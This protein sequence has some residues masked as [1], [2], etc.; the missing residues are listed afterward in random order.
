MS[1]GRDRRATRCAGPLRVAASSVRQSPAARAARRPRLRRPGW[2]LH[3]PHAPPWI[4]THAPHVSQGNPRTGRVR[5]GARRFVGAQSGLETRVAKLFRDGV[6]DPRDVDGD[7]RGEDR[8]ALLRDGGGGREDRPDLLLERRGLP[9]DGAVDQAPRHLGQL[10]RGGRGEAGAVHA[11]A[12]VPARGRGSERG[13]CVGTRGRG[14][15]VIT[16]M[17]CSHQMMP[18]SWQNWP[19]VVR[20]P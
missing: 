18:S 1:P 15:G 17:A 7:G 14:A 20:I 13:G 5:S 3:A 9:A 10:Q 2:R 11:V 12:G 4:S 8:E 16:H 6:E 19:T